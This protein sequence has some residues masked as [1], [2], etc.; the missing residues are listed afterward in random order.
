MLLV[1]G[2]FDLTE[3]SP[4]RITKVCECCI[5]DRSVIRWRHRLVTHSSYTQTKLN[6][7]L[8]AFCGAVK[9]ADLPQQELR[10]VISF[11][12][13]DEAKLFLGVSRFCICTRPE[14]VADLEHLC[15]KE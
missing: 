14:E 10:R 7:N 6:L 13:D 1:L 3:L 8:Y 2:S 5:A 11:F 4:P 9:A 15:V 12:Q